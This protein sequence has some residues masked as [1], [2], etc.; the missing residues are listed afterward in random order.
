MVCDFDDVEVVL[1]DE[2]RISLV[3]QPLQNVYELMDV[4]CVET[5]CGLVQYINGIAC[6]AL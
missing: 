1:D 6:G 5:C 3:S 2:D 4:G